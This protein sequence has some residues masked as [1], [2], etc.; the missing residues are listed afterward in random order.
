MGRLK[1]SQIVTIMVF[2]MEIALNLYIILQLLGES[3]ISVFC[4]ARQAK[5]QIAII[6]AFLKD[7]FQ[8]EYNTLQYCYLSEKE[9]VML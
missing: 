4:L 6:L 5:E 8:K 3:R 7:K 9:A 1:K 2:L